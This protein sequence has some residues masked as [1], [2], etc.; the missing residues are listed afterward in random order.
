[1]KL[2]TSVDIAA[3]EKKIRYSD[4]I[5]LLGSCFADNIGAKFEEH[6]FQ[7]TINPYGTLYNPASIAL[8]IIDSRCPT[9]DTRIIHH[10]GLWHSMMHHGTFSG[11]DKEE[12]M[13]RCEQSREQLQGALNEASTIVVTFGTAWVYEMNGEV[14]ANCHKIPA[15]RFVRRCM[16]V[17]EIVDMWQPIVDSMPTKHWIFTVSPIRHIK[18]GLHANQVSKAILL[19]AV[20][21]LGK[22]YFPSY[23]IMMDELRDY[24]FYAE[25]MVHLSNQG[26]AYIWEKFQ[27]CFI[28]SSTQEWMQKIERCNKILAH[29]PFDENSES[30]MELYLRTQN[31]LKEILD[32]LYTEL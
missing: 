22:S 1:M 21:Q 24:R 15:N 4:K 5:L 31:E 3:S 12:V 10:N 14:V 8:S 29:R 30:A 11:V 16:I 17:Q 23:E 6:Y 18:D 27:S 19:Q 9:P 7:T 28:A 25:D 32:K 13:A 26:I 2:Y 20:D